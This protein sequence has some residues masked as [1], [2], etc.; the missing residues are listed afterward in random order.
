M[1]SQEQLGPSSE[2]NCPFSFELAELLV[3]EACEMILVDSMII[4]EGRLFCKSHRV[5]P[6]VANSPISRVLVD[7]TS[8]QMLL[9]P[10]VSAV[11]GRPRPCWK[12]FGASCGLRGY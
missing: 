2:I 4:I 1:S 11:F 7:N 3:A 10:S 9:F 12:R 8:A 5:L 6:V